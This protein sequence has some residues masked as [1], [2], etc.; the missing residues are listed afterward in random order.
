MTITREKL[1]EIYEDATGLDAKRGAGRID[2]LQ[3]IVNDYS[4]DEGGFSITDEPNEINSGWR[5]GRK[6]SAGSRIGNKFCLGYSNRGT[7][8]NNCVSAVFVTVHNMPDTDQILYDTPPALAQAGLFKRT[9][10]ETEL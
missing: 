4:L 10:Q 7:S 5:N 9:E 1:E 2:R 3:E 8:R 6:W